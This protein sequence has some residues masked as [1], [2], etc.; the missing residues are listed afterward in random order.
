VDFGTP[1]PMKSGDMIKVSF[2]GGSWCGLVVEM[3]NHGR[4]A[5]IWRPIHGFQ[6][7]P[8]F[9][10]YHMEVISESR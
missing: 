1:G 4:S 6:S 2:N 9:S 5:M 7:W 10:H 3:F 8:V